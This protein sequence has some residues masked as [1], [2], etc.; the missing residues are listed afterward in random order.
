[1]RCAALPALERF[2]ADLVIVASGFDASAYDPL[3]RML[4]HSA[5]YRDLAQ[6]MLTRATVAS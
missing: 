6:T 2:G 3:G 5:S 4:L 1:M